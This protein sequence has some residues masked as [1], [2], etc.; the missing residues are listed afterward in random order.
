MIKM[1]KGERTKKN[2]KI[3]TVNNKSLRLFQYMFKRCA[4]EFT[5]AAAYIYG[6]PGTITIFKYKRDGNFKYY[7]LAK[8]VYN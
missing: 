8:P 1:V 6:V 7:A 4:T 5:S 3:K 2:T